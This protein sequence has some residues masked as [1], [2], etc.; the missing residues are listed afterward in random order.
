[1]MDTSLLQIGAYALIGLVFCV[2]AILDGFDLGIGMLLPWLGKTGREKSAVLATIGPVWDGNEVWLVMGG[3]YLFAFFPPAFGAALST[4]WAPIM[5]AVFALM[6]RAAAFEFRYHGTERSHAVW[7][8]VLC[9]TSWIVTLILGIGFG[10]VISGLNVTDRSA[11][12]LLQALVAPLP[13]ATGTAGCCLFLL[14]GLAWNALKAPPEVAARNNRLLKPTAATA[15]LTTALWTGCLAFTIPGAM[16]KPLFWL[17]CG[18]TLMALLLV[19]PASKRSTFPLPPLSALAVAGAMIAALAAHFPVLIR[20][21]LASG[22]TLSA[23]GASSSPALLSIMVPFCAAWMLIIVFFT[24]YV[25]R[26]FKGRISDY[27]NGY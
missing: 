1:M 4:L 2:Y 16:H 7:D 6:L 18:A 23:A 15:L 19:F 12:A 5:A 8:S 9:A 27:D 14:H 20:A 17:G 22:A 13:I 21:P 26:T 10:T 3:A 25:Y 24:I 11:D